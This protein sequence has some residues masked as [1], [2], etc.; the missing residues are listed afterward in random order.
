MPSVLLIVLMLCVLVTPDTARSDCINPSWPLWRSFVSRDID[1]DGYIV[2][3]QS[4]LQHTTSEGQA[5]GMFLALV[6]NDRVTFDR[7]LVWTDRT[8]A[9]GHLGPRLPAWQWTRQGGVIDANSAADADL[10][11]AYTLLE[12]GRLWTAP[13]LRQRGMHL[14]QS[15]RA[16]EVVVAPGTGPVL[17]PGKNGF[18]DVTGALRLNP[19]YSPLPVLRRLAVLDP[20]GPW[21]SLAEN[22]TRMIVQSTPHGTVPDWVIWQPEEGYQNDAVTGATGSYDA[23]RVYLWAGMS[24]A[25]DGLAQQQL[26]A[27]HGPADWLAGHSAL[28]ERFATANGNGAGAAPFGFDAAILPYLKTQG[29]KAAYIA[30]KKR[31]QQQLAL[32]VQE[33]TGSD[34]LRYYDLVLSLFGLGW[35][36]GRFQ[37]SRD[38]KLQPRWEN[39]CHSIGP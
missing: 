34:T 28:P 20:T 25:E 18:A 24:A 10:W 31:L 27:L 6:A 39:T 29:K 7:L 3:L 2:D 13:A 11:L 22:S 35:S 1:R 14:L 33:G 37:F 21:R 32:F 17:L 16:Q 36:E 12:A 15:I 19:S 26:A 9:G 4:P 8:L 30:L 38:G 23:I 5:Y